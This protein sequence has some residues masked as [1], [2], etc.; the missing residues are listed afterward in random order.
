MEHERENRALSFNAKNR[1]LCDKVPVLP[2][3]KD[4]T[5]PSHTRISIKYVQYKGVFPAVWWAR[6]RDRQALQQREQN[7]YA[8]LPY[9]TSVK[10]CTPPQNTKLLYIKHHRTD[11]I[12]STEQQPKISSSDAGQQDTTVRYPESSML[13]PVLHP[14]PPPGTT[15]A[16]GPAPRSDAG[17][18]PPPTASP[19]GSVVA[20]G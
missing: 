12:L 13:L 19:A 6:E 17:R 18:G 3:Q 4:R 10:H 20:L 14:G 11:I 7:S 2:L 16:A 5:L 15:G 9:S 1:P 8:L